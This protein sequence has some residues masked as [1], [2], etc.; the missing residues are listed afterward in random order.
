MKQNNDFHDVITGMAQLG[1]IYLRI[2]GRLKSMYENNPRLRFEAR[3]LM[4]KM[5]YEAPSFNFRDLVDSLLKGSVSVPVKKEERLLLYRYARMFN[6]PVL[7]QEVTMSFVGADTAER[8]KMSASLK[9]QLAIFPDARLGFL[10][11][12]DFGYRETD[13]FPVR[14]EI[15]LEIF[16]MKRI[17]V[18]TLTGDGR[19]ET[20]T[21]E[22]TI[23]SHK[24]MIGIRRDEWVEY[25]LAAYRKG[26][27]V[28]F[29]FREPEKEYR[30][31]QWKTDLPE[32][33]GY[34]FTPYDVLCS[35]EVS[36][37][38]SKYNLVYEGLI[39]ESATLEDIFE[40]FNIDRPDDFT[41][42][43][44]SVGDVVAWREEETWRAWYVDS[45]G[46]K[47]LEGFF[48][49]KTQ[50]VIREEKEENR[51]NPQAEHTQKHPPDKAEEKTKIRQI[52]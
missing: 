2:S 14:K 44:L 36:I 17:T 7:T 43:S 26:E 5:G 28:S 32:G 41:G 11:L 23:T 18:Y 8:E 24:G 19:K 22:K 6:D 39:R 45:F 21:D 30:I 38:D 46:F 52:R 51:D 34:S 29:S 15:A 49:S 25:Y 40:M 1:E 4:A 9:A 42:H 33:K 48:A 35:M 31:Y 20:A 27:T 12:N 37:T 47:K 16:A 3:Q 10:D 50:T 13:I